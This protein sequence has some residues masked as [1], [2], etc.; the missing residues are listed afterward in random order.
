M[1]KV[2]A[3]FKDLLATL[4]QIEKHLEKL[5]ST[6]S[7]GGYSERGYPTLRTGKNQYDA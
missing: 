2:I 1:K 3:Y 7:G 5:S 6:V 4:K